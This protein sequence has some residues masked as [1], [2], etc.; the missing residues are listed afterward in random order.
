[1]YYERLGA[2]Q[3]EGVSVREPLMTTMANVTRRW[4]G[5]TETEPVL[6]DGKN[7]AKV[8]N[9]RILSQIARFSAGVAI[10]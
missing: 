7:I 2:G 5:E 6:V 8:V 4:F 1:V 3:A 9:T 10:L